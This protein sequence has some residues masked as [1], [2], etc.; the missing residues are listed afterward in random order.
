MVT[1]NRK[2]FHKSLMTRREGTKL[3]GLGLL[4]RRS[5][6]LR[7]IGLAAR[8]KYLGKSQ[9]C[10]DST[11]QM[12]LTKGSYVPARAP[13]PIRESST[14]ARIDFGFATSTKGGPLGVGEV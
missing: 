1:A 11:G 3:G 14:R 12:V 8:L 10:I 7:G 13:K 2:L 5:S 4:R 6:R 9:I